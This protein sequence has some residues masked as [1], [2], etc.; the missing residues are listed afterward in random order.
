MA[1]QR[2]WFAS[3]EE[4]TGA[5]VARI[6]ISHQQNVKAIARE[7]PPSQEPIGSHAGSNV[8][9]AV[10]IVEFSANLARVLLAK[11][12]PLLK[13]NLMGGLDYERTNRT[14]F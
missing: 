3:E 13:L 1:I 11:N 6:K 10:P 12:R 2:N 5:P 7:L 4:I 9:M 8:L 14:L